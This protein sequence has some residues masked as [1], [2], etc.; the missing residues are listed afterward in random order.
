VIERIEV[1]PVRIPMGRPFV[2]AGHRRTRTAS[3]LVAVDAAGRRGWGEAAPRPYVTNE[4]VETV[5]GA[6][7]RLGP[8][9]LTELVDL[10][11]FETAMRNLA[12]LELPGGPAARAAVEVALFDLACRL[13]DR[14]G[15][16]GLRCVAPTLV[17]R[18]PVP[19]PVSLVLDLGRN[20]P[21]LGTVRHVKVKASADIDDCL[22]RVA[23]V[24]DR[25]GPGTGISV[26]VNGDWDVS[27]A[28]DVID[29]ARR[30]RA[31]G[32]AW[33]E[34]PVAA[35]DWAAMAEIRRATGMPVMLD[36]SCSG[37]DDLDTATRLGAADYVNARIS[38]CGGIFPTLRL[39]AAARERGIG[40]QLGVH[41]G[42]IG[43]LPAAARLLTCAVGGLVTA[44]A[45]RPEEWFPQPLTEPPLL[46]DR[47]RYVVDPLPGNGIGIEPSGALRHR[48]ESVGIQ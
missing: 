35:R 44:E 2:H 13:H 34:E 1:H 29:A 18:E 15:L 20:P 7:N 42:E 26:D 14:D 5:L 38:K 37:L 4:S 31:L 10:T 40:A 39:I 22:R 24:R 16:A 21:D 23:A 9:D 43:P 19:A 11:D 25:F 12:R 36:E 8:N 33:L 30:L 3:V 48:L 6:L 28:S 41:V 47:T 27:V 45:G 46:V 32:V 17:A